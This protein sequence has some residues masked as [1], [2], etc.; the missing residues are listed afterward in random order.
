MKF[1]P[2]RGA[3]I[4]VA[5][6]ASGFSALAYQTAWQRVLTQVIGSDSISAVLTVVM[7]MIW[8]AVGSEVARRL[9]S[10]F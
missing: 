5:F 7:F 9:L 3:L 8:L 4:A 10:R 6:A 2:A 1:R